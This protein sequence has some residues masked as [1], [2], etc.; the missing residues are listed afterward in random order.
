MPFAWSRKEN[1]AKPEPSMTATMKA[2]EIRCRVLRPA[3]SAADQRTKNSRI[4]WGKYFKVKRFSRPSACA[5][6]PM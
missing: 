4:I 5:H 1:H 2:V 6:V 3:A